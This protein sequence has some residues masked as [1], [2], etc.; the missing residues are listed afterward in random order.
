[1]DG[2]ATHDE[3]SGPVA[4]RAAH[5]PA[6]PADL[7]AHVET[8]RARA[9]AS[10]GDASVDEALRALEG[11]ADAPLSRHVAAFDAVHG[12]LQDRLAE[13]QG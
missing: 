8:A 12:A 11:L 6:S 13:T 1:M 7:A 4:P 3:G 5:A 9:E 10:T 2:P